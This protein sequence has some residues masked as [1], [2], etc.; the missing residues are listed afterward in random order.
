MTHERNEIQGMIPKAPQHVATIDTDTGLAEFID[1]MRERDWIAIDTEF[2]RE[3]TYYPKLCLVQIADTETVGLIDVLALSDTTPLVALLVDPDVCKVFHSAEQDLEVL[4]HTYGR[5]PAPVFDTQIAAPLLGFDDQMGYARLIEAL[6]DRKLSKS[7]TRTDWSQRP[8]PAGALDYAADDAR[9]LS[10]AYRVLTRR[11]AE[12]ERLDW[13]ADDFERLV[14]PSRFHVD[15]RRAWRRVKAT[16]RLAPQAQQIIAELAD[17][18]EQRA[19]ESDR[20]RRWVLA[21]NTIVALA[22]NQPRSDIELADTPDLPSK[23]LERHGAALLACIERGLARPAKPL[24]PN[25]GPPDGPTKRQIKTGM[26]ALGHAAERVDIPASAIASR[27]D[28]A[29]IV[30]GE[31]DGRLLQGWRASVAGQAVVDA[32]ET[33]QADAA[34]RN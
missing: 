31:R 26:N 20:P 8:L 34:G 7:H 27:Q 15:T 1:R 14:S 3:R 24:N 23:T 16:H 6:L 9:Y 28:V 32:V 4:Y 12:A 22:E 2:L 30:A 11:L 13:L 33:A 19:I 17:W 10:V 29:A 18:R 25:A 5:M 21:D